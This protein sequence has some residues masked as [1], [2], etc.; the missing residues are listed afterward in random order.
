MQESGGVQASG[1]R[2][3][4]VDP[5]RVRHGGTESSADHMEIVESMNRAVYII[6]FRL[7]KAEGII[8][9]N[10]RGFSKRHTTSPCQGLKETSQ[11]PPF[12][13]GSGRLCCAHAA[14]SLH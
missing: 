3:Y 13:Q 14:G 1:G 7:V 8:W 5:S 10:G 2:G 9:I 12:G 4:P 6:N 11:S